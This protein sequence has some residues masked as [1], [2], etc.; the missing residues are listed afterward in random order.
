MVRFTPDRANAHT[1][2]LGASGGGKSRLTELLMRLNL[3]QSKGGFCLLDPH[4]SLYHSMVN[5]LAMKRPDL[6]DRVILIDPA[7]DTQPVVGF[8]PLPEAAN[9]LDFMV[10]TLVE[11][12][13]KAWGQT[14]PKSTPRIARWLENI[15]H[16][17]AVNDLTLLETAPLIRTSNNAERD[18]LL[19]GVQND[20]IRD[21]WMMFQKAHPRER[22]AYMEGASNRLR[23]FLQSPAIRNMIGQRDQRIDFSQV[24]EEG[25]IVLINLSGGTSV[26]RENMRLLGVMIVNEIF[27]CAKLRNPHQP[28]LLPFKL[29]IDEFGQFITQEIAF[30]LEECRKYGLF[31]TLAHQHLEQLKEDDPYL[32]ASV[33]TN[34]KN[35]I[36][37]GGLSFDD[38]EVMR[39]EIS[40]GFLD[41]M[42]VKDEVFQTKQRQIEET[43]VVRG[44]SRAKA[45]G[46]T[47][48]ETSGTSHSTSRTQTHGESTVQS[49]SQS[50]GRSEGTS[51]TEGRSQTKSVKTSR[52]KSRT[53][54][55]GSSN[56]TSSGSTTSQSNGSSN[57]FNTSTSSNYYSGNGVTQGQ[58]NNRGSNMSNST[59]SS[60]SSSSST[61]QSSSYGQ[62]ESQGSAFGIT[63]SI[64][65]GIN[66]SES[67]TDQ[68]GH[69]ETISS[70]KAVGRSEG[71]SQ[72]SSKGRSSTDTETTSESIVPF[73]RSEEY[74]EMSSRTF[75]SLSELE[76]MATATI[77][78]Q[79]IGTAFV[80]FGIEEPKSVKITHVPDITRNPRKFG[81]FL[82][83][84]QAAHTAL[85]QTSE[86][87]RLVWQKRQQ[88]V[89][90]GAIMFDK[91]TAPALTL[92][93]D[94][95]DDLFE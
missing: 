40:T 13:L 77:K 32:Y 69:S 86:A 62:S 83:R 60:S 29:Y 46:E 27:R 95:A 7:N 23:A 1:H 75:W 34:C 90:G 41:L 3:T 21:D 79:A 6:A 5:Y 58:G 20:L 33:L 73:Q 88:A 94:I 91:Q 19:T 67:Q 51:S 24:I 45:F 9:N 59:G 10:S 36:V 16:V 38:A 31:L 57:G 28:N 44:T 85:Y 61:N 66:S 15:F 26:T 89:F 78:N 50:L 52:G 55:T 72:S 37:F 39:K 82:D 80:R 4:G 74:R 87:A 56:S 42:R 12:C 70:S 71:E 68:Q 25:K 49:Q 64:S 43:R 11:G 14:D 53:H 63:H 17:I 30:A 8:N 76:H 65:D 93:D 54:S 81:I 48:S 2:I 47:Q 92:K 35:R 18:K 84:N 22:E